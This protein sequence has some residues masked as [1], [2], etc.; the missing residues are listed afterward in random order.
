MIRPSVWPRLTGPGPGGDPPPLP[1]PFPALEP[2]DPPVAVAAPWPCVAR[3]LTSR[4]EDDPVSAAA[5]SLHAV[6]FGP[7][8]PGGAPPGSGTQADG[9]DGSVSL[10][11][12]WFGPIQA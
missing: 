11:P 12:G 9:S 8:S 6:V 7:F 1:D 4:A 2:P 10:I 5:L 3:V